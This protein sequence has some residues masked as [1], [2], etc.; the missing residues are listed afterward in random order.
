MAKKIYIVQ[1]GFLP[2]GASDVTG[3]RNH[4]F[5]RDRGAKDRA[6]AE[7]KKEIE[8]NGDYRCRFRVVSAT[9]CSRK[10]TYI[11]VFGFKSNARTL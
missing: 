3:W 5:C 7:C 8:K 2:A 6:V 4:L 11:H 10:D 9:D 1:G